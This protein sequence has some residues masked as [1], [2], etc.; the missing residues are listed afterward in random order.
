MTCFYFLEQT[1]AINYADDAN[2][3]ACDMDLGN[4]MRRLEHDSLIVIEW[5]ECNYIEVK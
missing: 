5:F 3:Y 2:L 1:G 4:L